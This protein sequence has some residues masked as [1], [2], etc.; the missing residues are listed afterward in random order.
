MLVSALLSAL[1][2]TA[3]ACQKTDEV[4]APA[5]LLPPD[6]MVNLLVELHTL[7]AR[8]ES[9]GL[10]PDSSRAL[11]RQEQKKIYWRHEVSDSTFT[12]SFRYYAIQGQELNKLYKSVVD[13]LATLEK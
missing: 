7:E 5:Q 12:Q 8:V 3:S 6:K 13:S 11:F 10:T 4:P 9:A 2:L 1:L